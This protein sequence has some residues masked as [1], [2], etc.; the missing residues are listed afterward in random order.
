MSRIGTLVSLIGVGMAVAG[1][2]KLAG[3]RGYLR[4]VPPLGLDPASR[5][6]WPA[7]PR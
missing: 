5:C 6:G 2:D 3:D 7:S 4:L 1:I